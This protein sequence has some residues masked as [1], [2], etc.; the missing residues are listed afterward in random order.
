MRQPSITFLLIIILV[1]A[2]W[3]S[4]VNSAVK[5]GIEY[6]I[7]TDYSKLSE[8]E[9]EKK[10]SEYFYLAQ[11]LPDKTVNEDMTNALFLYNVLLN[12]NPNSIEYCTKLGK[13][14]DKTGNDRYAKGNFSRAIGINNSHPEPYFCF[15]EF[16]YKRQMYRKALKYYNEAYIRGYRTNY[17]LL[18]KIG[19]IYEKF[20]DTR[21][22]LKYLK[23]ASKQNPNSE[24]DSKIKRIEAFDGANSEYY[25]D[26][27]IR[28]Y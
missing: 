7:P 14:Y 15:G 6:S 2:I 26:T 20:G 9:L 12:I 11:K 18:Y 21:S 13:L 10:A 17:E 3:S 25:S 16:Y 27:R 23:D 8:V 1:M 24:L 19:D 28:N 5:G 22:A 4:P